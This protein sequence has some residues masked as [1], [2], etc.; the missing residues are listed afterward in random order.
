V[1]ELL[2]GEEALAPPLH[3]DTVVRGLLHKG[4]LT[5]VYG[6]PKSG[7][8]FLVTDLALAVA[9]GE[10]EMWME[11]RIMQH[12]PVLYVACEGHGGFWKRLCAMVPISNRT[13][14]HFVLAKGRPKLIVDDSGR[15]YHWVP[16]PDD[17]NKACE[18]VLDRL[19]H[20]PIV[21]VIDT[22]FRSFGGANVND[23]AHMNSYIAAAQGVADEGIAVVL[24]HHSTK[25]GNTPAG[26]VSLIG[27]AD[28]LIAVRKDAE[29]HVW[30]VEEAKDDAETPPRAFKLEVVESI[31]D[32]FGDYVSSCKVIDL[33]DRKEEAK[34]SRKLAV[35][36]PKP[37]KAPR[38]RNPNA[39]LVYQALVTLFDK[40]DVP[41][42]REIVPG[43]PPRLSVARD[44]LKDQLRAGGV[45]RGTLNGHM[46]GKERGWLRDQLV[47]LVARKEIVMNAEFIALSDPDCITE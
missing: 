17:I 32:A 21:V 40:P 46:T 3:R 7:K 12:G 36:D 10:R 31:A 13:L 34:P 11:H 47:S 18:R 41:Q 37:P 15:G 25:V 27:A 9:E 43:T 8:S 6:L 4:S 14:D 28:T 29:G 26:S 24:V 35:K 22:V 1:L 33:R 38:A 42:K 16:H 44:E 45:I 30:E 19:S 39:E 20:L 2:F 5:V 23:S